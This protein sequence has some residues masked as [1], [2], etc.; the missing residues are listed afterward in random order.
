MHWCA[1]QTVKRIE[2]WYCTCLYYSTWAMKVLLCHKILKYITIWSASCVY[3][4]IKS[5]RYHKIDAIWL[6]YEITALKFCKYWWHSPGNNLASS[7]SYCDDYIIYIIVIRQFTTTYTCVF[8]CIRVSLSVSKQSPWYKL[9]YINMIPY[10][11]VYEC[12]I[13][14]RVCL[15]VNV[16]THI[17]RYI[18]TPGQKLWSFFVKII[19]HTSVTHRNTSLQL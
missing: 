7:K 1:G 13:C 3:C 16:Y 5:C 11:D 9:L 6:N 19:F 17:H 2:D 15:S 18:Y 14:V 8:I 4:P 12:C 10:I